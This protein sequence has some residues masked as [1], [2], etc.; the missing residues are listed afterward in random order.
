MACRPQLGGT[1]VQRIERREIDGPDT[2]SDE[3]GHAVIGDSWFV[4][5]DS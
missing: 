4:I 2:R 5:G 1:P 3:G